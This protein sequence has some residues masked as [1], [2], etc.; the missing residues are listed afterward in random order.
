MGGSLADPSLTPNA[1]V[2]TYHAQL[3]PS[4][5]TVNMWTDNAVTTTLGLLFAGIAAL[6]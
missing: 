4:A 5:V 3:A 1:A 2:A 6:Y